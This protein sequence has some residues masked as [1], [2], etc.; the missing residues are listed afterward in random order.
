MIIDQNTPYPETAIANEVLVGIGGSGMEKGLETSYQ[1]LS[2]ASSAGPG[3]AFFRSD[4]T[5]VVIY[6][7]DEPDYSGSWNSYIN[8]YDNL[9]PAG[10]FIPYAVIGDPPAGC[11]IQ[12][13]GGAQYGRGYWDIIDYYGGD[14][15]SIC[16]TDWG[17]QLQN[18]ANSMAGRR[19]YEIGERDP[20]EATITVSVNGQI[21]TDW[22][23]DPNTNKVI[24]ADGHV[25]DSGQTIEIEDAVWGCEE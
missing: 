21:T 3:S 13:Y 1:A 2:S 11:T 14:W 15:Y 25:P 8:F 19:S 24:F 6:V 17:V 4:A 20:I 7:S 18:M 9:K 16:A 22:E 10:Q 5:L 23:Y 12:N